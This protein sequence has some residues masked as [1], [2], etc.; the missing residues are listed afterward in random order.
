MSRAS[1]TL[2]ALVALFG[3]ALAAHAETRSTRPLLA[4]TFELRGKFDDGRATTVELTIEESSGGALAVRRTARIEGSREKL[5][6]SASGVPSSESALDISFDVS[7]TDGIAKAIAGMD[8][9]RRATLAASYRL[10][11]DGLRLEETVENGSR[12]ATWRRIETKGGRAIA[13]LTYGELAA[14][15]IPPL[16]ED[17]RRSLE[18][19]GPRTAPP[20]V[21][22]LRRCLGY[23]RDYVDVFAFA[24][25]SDGDDDTWREI[26]DDLDTGY[27]AMGAFKDLF[28]A[29]GIEDPKAAHYDRKQL[30]ERREAMLE[31]L[32]HFRKPKRLARYADYLS[33]PKRHR[34]EHR[35]LAKLYWRE[36][37]I[38]PKEELSGVENIARLERRLLGLARDELAETERLRNIARP[39]TTPSFHA[40]RK[41][42]R[43]TYKLGAFFPQIFEP[44]A[45]AAPLVAFITDVTDRYGDLLDRVCAV[46]L[47]HERGDERAATSIEAEVERSWT[48]LRA[49]TREKDVDG[50]LER[51][52]EMVERN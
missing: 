29:Q 23:V 19:V 39:K 36:A 1:F 20:D 12:R 49:W 14:L 50:S 52:R 27:S 42:L 46:E 21:R 5:A 38:E 9:A 15:S 43:C 30:A 4:G 33:H 34:L 25:P 45:D 16:F 31:W 7:E 18:T 2:I 13:D 48:T 17:V 44:G 8:P 24:Y 32:D 22:D 26:R 6:W 10:S 37:G 11:A 41:S 35:D 3:S 40:F 47:A 51:L 28:D